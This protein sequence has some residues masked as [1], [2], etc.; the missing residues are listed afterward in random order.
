[1]QTRGDMETEGW[2]PQ[3][4]GNWLSFLK[5]SFTVVIL[6]SPQ[7]NRIWVYFQVADSSLRERRALPRSPP[8][9]AGGGVEPASPAWL[10]RRLLPAD[11]PD[12]YWPHPPGLRQRAAH[13]PP[14]PRGDALH[15]RWR[16]L[17]GRSL[18]ECPG[19]AGGS[20]PRSPLP[21][22][23]HPHHILLDTATHRWEPEPIF[24]S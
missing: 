9:P 12:P 4:M 19:A 8:R 15:R 3:A 22:C 7:E 5:L 21:G 16:P 6:M 2:V 24:T 23:A 17:L 13:G 11:G 10:S 18:R 14:R 20:C 1:M